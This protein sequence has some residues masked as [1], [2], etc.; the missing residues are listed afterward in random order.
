M[1]PI[2]EIKNLTKTY[3]NFKLDHLNLTL[4]KGVIMG[5]IGENGAGKSTTIKL[6]MDIIKK[7]SGEVFLFGKDHTT[8]SN[9]LKEQIGVVFDASHFPENLTLKDVQKIMSCT[10]KTWD[11][12]QYEYYI[13]RFSLTDKMLIKEYSRGMKMKLSLSVALSHHAKLLILDEATGGLDPVIRDNILDI[14]LEFIQDETNSI[15]I[16]SHIISDLEKICDYIAFIHK[17]KLI[18]NEPKDEL[19]EK[20][21]IVKC[22]ED[23]YNKIP[24]NCIVGHRKNHFGVEALVFK[25]MVSKNLVTDNASLEDMM[26]YYIKEDTK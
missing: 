5:F 26:L 9:S 23:E 2:L 13:K 3:A 15:F 25:N 11:N 8:I 21:A 7:D 6:I 1:E 17:G 10:Y 14:L 18:F 22:S 4:P 19:Y 16:S 12:T 20:Y 24:K